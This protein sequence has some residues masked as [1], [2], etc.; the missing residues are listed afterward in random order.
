MVNVSP[1][2]YRPDPSVPFRAENSECCAS[3][4]KLVTP[5]RSWLGKRTFVNGENEST[6][7]DLAVHQHRQQP[8]AQGGEFL[9]LSV[10]DQNGLVGGLYLFFKRIE[11]M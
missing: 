8:V 5:R 9:V 7:S 4:Q 6:N 2:S 11:K 10:V 1:L 3:S